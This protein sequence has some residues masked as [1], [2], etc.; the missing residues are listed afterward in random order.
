M[1]EII[2]GHFTRVG[3]MSFMVLL[4]I[5]YQL[6]HGIIRTIHLSFTMFYTIIYICIIHE[7]QSLQPIY[8]TA[9]HRKM[10]PK[11][12]KVSKRMIAKLNLKY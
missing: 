8:D 12:C 2:N 1:P 3:I 6:Q 5:F 9:M 7:R 10:M 4:L 11:K